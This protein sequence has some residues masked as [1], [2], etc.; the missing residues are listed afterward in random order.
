MNVLVTGATGFVGRYIL[1]ELLARG[2]SVRGLAR[3]IPDDSAGHSDIE[4]VRGDITDP[5]SLTGAFDG[6]DAVVHLVGIIDE[7]PSKGVT[8][9]RIHE[10]GT[11]HV[12]Q[13]ARAAGIDT[14]IHMSAN[15]AD[16]NGESAYQ[17]SKFAAEEIVRGAGFKHWTV[18]RPALVFG[19]PLPGQPEFCTRLYRTLLRP[20]PVWPV[21]GDG[22][23]RLQPVAVEDVASVFV[24]ALDRPG[25]AGKTY[26]VAGPESFEYVE[27]LRRI[28]RGAGLS[29]RPM[30][31]QPLWLVR[32]VVGLLGGSLLPIS[33]DQLTML[34]SGNTCDIS[35]MMEDFDVEPLPFTEENLSYVAD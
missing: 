10:H 25:T 29:V 18:F 31:H 1:E 21:F 34:V 12:V 2:H 15:G 9:E 32:P 20:F 17:T 26:G 27:I 4:I 22:K 11:H 13:A 7:H 28:A 16:P 6:M 35:A 19:R 23:Y 33:E 14:F 24:Q 5:G 30:I 8:F 3:S